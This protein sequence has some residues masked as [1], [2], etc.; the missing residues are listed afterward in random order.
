MTHKNWS[1]TT[2]RDGKPVATEH[3][4][5][6]KQALS[7]IRAAMVGEPVLKAVRNDQ[8]QDT[9]APAELARAA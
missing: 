6:N 4:L 5:D 9:V 1:F 3:N 2:Y 8:E 7:A